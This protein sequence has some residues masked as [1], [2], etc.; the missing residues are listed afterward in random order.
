MVKTFDFSAL[1]GVN[2]SAEAKMKMVEKLMQDNNLVKTEFD[3]E[4]LTKSYL[5]MNELRIKEKEEKTDLE[6]SRYKQD[7][8]K[9][10]L[11]VAANKPVGNGDHVYR[12]GTAEVIIKEADKYYKWLIEIPS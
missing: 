6:F 9:R 7:C 3:K 4:N 11:E 12:T 5:K 10:A 2:I 1:E 8:R